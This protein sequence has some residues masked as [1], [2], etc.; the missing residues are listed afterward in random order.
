VTKPIAWLVEEFDSTGALVWSGLMTSEP[1]ELSWFK[2][3]KSKLHNVTITPLI[4]DTKNIK[5]V[6]NTKKYDSKKLTEAYIGN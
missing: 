4:A 1:T 5:K 2:D 3:L 6:T